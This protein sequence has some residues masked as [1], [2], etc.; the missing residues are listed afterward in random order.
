VEA[1]F[2]REVELETRG[3]P[4][5]TDILALVA[6]PGGLGVIAVEGKAREPFGPRVSEWNDSPGKQARLE[7]LCGHLGLEPAHVGELRYQLLHRTVSGLHE[8]NRYGA[9]E[10]LMLVHSFDPA[11]S[12]LEDYQRFAGA[13]GLTGAEL[14]A[15]TSTIVC[16]GINLRLAWVKER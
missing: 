2:E 8:A 4:S 13:L 5:Q 9:R 15:V 12:S 16:S 14:G 6:G 11:D 10:A 7:N 1:F 3:R